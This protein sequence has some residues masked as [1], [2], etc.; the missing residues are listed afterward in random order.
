MSANCLSRLVA[1]GL[2]VS[3]I[4]G[5]DMSRYEA[6]SLPDNPNPEKKHIPVGTGDPVTLYNCLIWNSDSIDNACIPLETGIPAE[7]VSE[8][9][10]FS[11]VQTSSL[12]GKSSLRPI[13][14]KDVKL[15][16]W[17]YDNITVFARDSS[18]RTVKAVRSYLPAH[19]YSIGVRNEGSF[20]GL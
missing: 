19:I 18:F 15:P 14:E 11:F 17:G 3:L 1:I 4:V 7:A 9:G 13:L 5:C 6:I 10:Y 16:E 2:C 20:P 8:S 12:D